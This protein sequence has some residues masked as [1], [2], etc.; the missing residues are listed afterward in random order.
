MAQKGKAPPAG[1]QDEPVTVFEVQSHGALSMPDHDGPKTRAECYDGQTYGWSESPSALA[2]AMDSCEPLFWAVYHLYDDF[3]Y[4]IQD[5]IEKLEG[6][7]A[8]RE[9][10]R[11]EDARRLAE[12]K[13][14][15]DA[16]PEY[17]NERLGAWVRG[18]DQ[19]SFREWF[20]PALEKWFAD[21]P[22]WG[23]EGDYLPASA[24]AEGAAV[25]FFERC[26]PEW[27]D[28]LGVEFVEAGHPGGSYYY[29]ALEGGLERA[30]TAAIERA[31]AAARDAGIPVRFARA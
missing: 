18:L 19:R 26:D 6:A 2:D 28:V 27:L 4:E 3:R 20:V 11:E 17:L 29:V 16:M 5:E 21:E 8:D 1:E 13:A 15:F 9:Q 10:E 12:L 23:R 14:R 30:D 24:S 31:N 7:A 25:E 22:D